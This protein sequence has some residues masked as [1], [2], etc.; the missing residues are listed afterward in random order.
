VNVYSGN[1]GNNGWVGLTARTL[2]PAQTY[3]ASASVKLND[4]YGGA[5]EALHW[6]PACHELGHVL[7]LGHNASSASCMYYMQSSNKYPTSDDRNL[8][9]R[10]Y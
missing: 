8:L 9:Q 2:N 1:Y 4:Y 3:Y 6:N 5:T 7:G 10:Y